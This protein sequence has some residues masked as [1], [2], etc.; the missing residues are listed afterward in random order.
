VIDFEREFGKLLEDT[1]TLLLMAYREKQPQP[2][3]SQITGW[4]PRAISYKLPAALLD[5][6]RLL[7]K[8]D[9]L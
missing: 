3:I 1:Q 4:S 6:A 8:A 2:I 7:D 5:L 9:L